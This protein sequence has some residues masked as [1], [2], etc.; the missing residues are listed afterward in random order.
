MNINCV[1]IDKSNY[2]Q[3]FINKIIFI[4]NNCKMNISHGMTFLLDIDLYVFHNSMVLAI[5]FIIIYRLKLKIVILIFY[6]YWSK[7]IICI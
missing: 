4:G 2:L 5:I 1:F 3:I 7:F 6:E